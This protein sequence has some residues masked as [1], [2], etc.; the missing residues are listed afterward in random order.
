MKRVDFIKNLQGLI[1][2]TGFEVVFWYIWAL[3]DALAS[4]FLLWGQIYNVT[5]MLN[6]T[7]VTY[8][9]IPV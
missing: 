8:D 4:L 3:S 2:V 9:I 1:N 6:M 7:L 5:L